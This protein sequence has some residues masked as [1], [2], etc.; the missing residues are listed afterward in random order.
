MYLQNFSK[1]S[2]SVIKKGNPSVNIA[3]ESLPTYQSLSEIEPE[4][5]SQPAPIITVLPSETQ[6][7]LVK[8]FPIRNESKIEP[9]E[10][11]IK[12]TAVE[13]NQIQAYIFLEHTDVTLLPSNL[14][15]NAITVI[16]KEREI[17]IKDQIEFI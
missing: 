9:T 16:N 13:F 2:P 3:P 17:F 7:T 8:A 11:K 4:I 6:I 10:N 14:P 5:E 15:P 12:I 1:I